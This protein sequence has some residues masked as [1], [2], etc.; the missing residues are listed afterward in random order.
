MVEAQLA[1]YGLPFE[2]QDLE[3]LFH[4]EAARERLSA[5]NPLAQVPTLALPDGAVMTESAAITLHLADITGSTELVP[6]AAEPGAAT[7]CAGWCSWSPISTRRLLMPTIPPV[8]LAFESVSLTSESVG[9]L[10]LCASSSAIGHG[11]GGAV[12]SGQ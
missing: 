6:A 12:D 1:W 11:E 2:T 4:S 10:K 8:R 7:S 5:V 9:N 3:D